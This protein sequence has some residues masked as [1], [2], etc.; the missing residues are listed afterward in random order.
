MTKLYLWHDLVNIAEDAPSS[1]GQ[2]GVTVI[3]SGSSS[4]KTSSNRIFNIGIGHDYGA[5][6]Y[7]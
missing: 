7:V 4:A 2:G 6:E 3:I 5:H 1:S